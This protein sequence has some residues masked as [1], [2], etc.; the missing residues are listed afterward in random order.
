M[1]NK[2][3]VPALL[4]FIILVTAGYIFNA[5]TIAERCW[6]W[7]IGDWLIN[8]SGGFV[9]RGLSGFTMM[10]L[11]D[12]LNIK[13][14]YTAM[15]V[16]VALYVG[17]MLLLYLSFF[18]KKINAWFV[19]VLL[20]PATLL[21][22]I[23]DPNAAGRKEI[24]LFF[25]F[26]LYLFCLRRKLLQ[27]IGGTILFSTLLL[28][29]TLFH[30]LVFFYTPYFILAAYLESKIS[31]TPINISKP[32]LVVAGSCIIMLPLY[33]FGKS[34]NGA[35]ICSS[36]MA[37]G[38]PD[39]ICL[40]TL[41][42]PAE[43]GYK[44]V[45]HFARESNYLFVYGTTFIL[46]LLPFLLQ[47]HYLKHPA[48]TIRRFAII[49]SALLIFSLPL[50]LLAV[51]WGRWLHIHF[52]LMLLIATMFLKDQPVSWKNQPVS[53]P[54]MWPARTTFP[55]FTNNLFF[56]LFVIAYTSLWSMPHFGNSK[57]FSLTKNFYSIKH[58]LTDLARQVF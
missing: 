45:I 13:L 11:S 2:F 46:S 27:S 43:Y 37:R 40:G 55:G 15:W 21:F 53:I 28:I 44:N 51:D 4:C 42:W 25:I 6:G 48:I 38:L 12:L 34:I 17:F 56:V 47:I 50:F 26:A 1:K 8:F 49:F 16:Q 22:A 14:N 31:N 7:V 24:I 3:W 33:F 23:F 29:A 10:Q 41:S 52:M 32:L 39:S 20:S 19:L 18:R 58:L 5:F 57:V 36:L 9:R 54:R 30:E 35:A